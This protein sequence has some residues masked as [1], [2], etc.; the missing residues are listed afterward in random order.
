MSA[1]NIWHT[2]CFSCA[3]EGCDKPLEST[4]VIER[5]GV[6]FCKACYSKLFELKEYGYPIGSDGSLTISGHS[7]SSSKKCESA[8]F[9]SN[10][11]GF[12]I[13]PPIES[14]NS[15]TNHFIESC[16]SYASTLQLRSKSPSVTQQQKIPNVYQFTGFQYGLDICCRCKKK[17]YHAEKVSGAGAERPWHQ[18]CYKCNRCGKR[19][20]SISV[21]TYEGEIYCGTCNNKY[22]ST[23]RKF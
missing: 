16:C 6:A 11:F 3:N 4:N 20:D 5:D 21:Q 10:S 23:R 22:H 1:E 12:G 9:S 14:Y 17:V 13:V 8:E 7:S 2:T 15:S 19:L 18:S